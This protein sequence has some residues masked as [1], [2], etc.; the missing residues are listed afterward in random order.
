MAFCLQKNQDAVNLCLRLITLAPRG[1][2]E[3]RFCSGALL[4]ELPKKVNIWRCGIHSRLSSQTL[5][6][7]GMCIPGLSGP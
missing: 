7:T 3:K 4:I 6:L 5:I 2:V 1:M